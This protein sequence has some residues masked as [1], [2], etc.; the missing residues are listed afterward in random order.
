MTNIGDKCKNGRWHFIIFGVI[1]AVAIGW[2]LGW[3]TKNDDARLEHLKQEN[4][5][6]QNS[7]DNLNRK[8]DALQATVNAALAQSLA[9][10][11]KLIRTQRE[12]IDS[13]TVSKILFKENERMM[14][15]KK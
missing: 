12:L 15:G 9:D 2:Q 1:V 6:L 11:E 8:N 7:V 13:Q 4:S 10:S 3:Q 5:R 14:D